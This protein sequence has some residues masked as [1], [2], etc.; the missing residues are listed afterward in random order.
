MK[1]KKR[2]GWKRKSQLHPHHH[3]V[4]W[5]FFIL[6]IIAVIFAGIHNLGS[7]THTSGNQG[8]FFSLG[9]SLTGA[10]V[11]EEIFVE[12]DL[13]PL[14]DIS[15]EAEG[16]E[17]TTNWN[18][19]IPG[20]EWVLFPDLDT[21]SAGNV[22]MTGTSVDSGFSTLV[23]YV[24]K[25]YANGTHDT[26]NWNKTEPSNTGDGFMRVKV[27]SNDE[28]YYL[29]ALNTGTTD[30][31]AIKKYSNDGIL[32]STWNF[33]LTG[34]FEDNQTDAWDMAIDSNDNLFVVG[35]GRYGVD[36]GDNNLF[37][38]KYLA[39]DATEDP[40]WNYSLDLG[41]LDIFSNIVVD[42]NDNVIAAGSVNIGNNIWFLQK[43]NNS[44]DVQW[45]MTFPV[46][47]PDADIPQAL[48]VDSNNDIYIGGYGVNLTA[49]GSE[50]DWRLKKVLA[51]GS[52][53]LT[54]NK[55]FSGGTGN[56]ESV[57]DISIDSNDNIYVTGTMN[58][59]GKMQWMIKKFNT[60]GSED[61]TLW[62]K[63]FDIGTLATSADSIVTDSSGNVFS[64]GV[65]GGAGSELDTGLWGG[66][67]TIK[68]FSGVN[69]APVTS[70]VVLNATNINNNT[71]QNLTTYWD[72]SDADGDNVKNITNW[73]INDTSI[74][75][76][77]MPF[78]EINATAT[79]N[80]W[81]YSGFGNNG[82]VT[83]ATWSATAGYDGFGAYQFD[84]DGDNI[85]L[86]N[87][88]SLNIS[89]AI[90]LEVWINATN[91]G[92]DGTL[93][94]YYKINETEL[95]T[96]VLDDTDYF[97]T[98]VTGIGDLNGDGV[99]DLAVGARG[100][101][102]S[103]TDQGA[104]Y[105]LFMDIS[106]NVDSYYKIN[107]TDL[108]TG[109]LGSNDLFGGSVENIGDLNGDGITDLAVG[110]YND[111]QAVYILFM[112]TNGTLNSYYKISES[113]LGVVLDINDKFG[114]AVTNIGD[115][116]DDGITDL[117]V[118]AYTDDDDID[119][120]P[121]ADQGA[122]Y[123]L[124]MNITGGVDSH[125]KINESDLGAGVLDDN[126]FFGISVAGIGDLNGDGVED[127]A[128]GAYADDDDIDAPPGNNQG[129]VYV[130][131][132]NITGG[133]DSYYKINESDLGAGRLDDSDFFGISLENI[134]DLN[135]D[136]IMDLAVGAVGDDDNIPSPGNGQGA[137]YVLFMNTTG[138]VD[139]YYK[140][141]ESDLG[142]GMLGVNDWFGYSLA[143]V[144]DLNNDG[145]VDLAVGVNGDD[146]D[147]DAPPGNGQGAVYVLFMNGTT[148]EVISKVGSYGINASNSYAV[149]YINNGTNDYSLSG[150]LNSHKWNQVVYTYDGSR[151]KIYINGEVKSDGP[152]TGNIIG[153]TGN[154]ILGDLFNG[155]IDDVKIYNRSLSAEQIFALYNNRTD[156]IVSQELTAGDNWSACITPNDG[157]EDGIE[158]CSGNLTIVAAADTTNPSVGTLV[159]VVNS[160]FNVS[161]VVEINATVTDD[162]A[163]SQVFVNITY[164]NST[165]EQYEL[166]L[167]GSNV[168]NTTFTVPTLTG[169]Y[170]LTF[171]ANDTNN[172]FNTTETSNFT[173][174]LS[175]GIIS[176]ST[177]LT[178]NVTYDGSNNQCFNISASDVT[179]DCNGYWLI[180][181]DNDT[182]TANAAIYSLGTDNVTVK[183][184]NLKGFNPRVI[185][186]I[187][188]TNWTVIDNNFTQASHNTSGNPLYI[189]SN[190][191]GGNNYSNNRFENYYVGSG[192]TSGLAVINFVNDDHNSRAENNY[193]KNFTHVG[194]GVSSFVLTTGQS[195][196]ITHN[197]N[198]IHDVSALSF[199]YP[200]GIIVQGTG[201]IITNNIVN[202]T[203]IAIINLITDTTFTNN[204][205]YNSVL[206]VAYGLA[207]VG[208]ATN[209]SSSNNTFIN[210]TICDSVGQAVSANISGSNY[211]SCTTDAF[212]SGSTDINFFTS[213]V[214]N[215]LYIDNGSNVTFT[216]LTI[217]N[218]STSSV[219]YLNLNVNASGVNTTADLNYANNTLYINSTGSPGLN[220]SSNLTFTGVSYANLNSYN[221][222][223]DEVNCTDCTKSGF[224]P[225]I[226]EVTSFS[227]YSTV[228]YTED[229][230]VSCGTITTNTTLTENLTVNGTC[231]TIGANNIVI[232]GAGYTIT[233]N[234]SSYGFDNDGY[235]NTVIK[236]FAG[237]NN[238]TITVYT[239]GHNQT[240]Y[241]NTMTCANVSSGAHC[242]NTFL[243]S[244]GNNIS[245]NNLTALGSSNSMGIF[246]FQSGANTTI[247]SNSIITYG[248]G[249]S[250]GISLT[251]SNNITLID[252]NITIFG[253][254][255]YGID[256]GG[257]YNN[258]SGGIINTSAGTTAYGIRVT[259]SADGNYFENIQVSSIN[260][261]E[262]YYSTVSS[263]DDFQNIILTGGTNLTIF[264]PSQVTI[265]VNT[266]P[267]ADPSGKQNLSDYL[268]IT[269]LTANGY[270]DFN[271]SYTDS[272]ITG[273][274]E[275]SIRINRYN[276]SSGEW[277]ELA[278]STVDTENNI[279][280][281]GNISSF[282]L[283]APFGS[284]AVTC[285]NVGSSIILTQNLTTDDTC[286]TVTA[287]NV[288]IDG[289]GY[290]IT[291][292]GSIFESKSGV[293]I[294]NR[295]NVTVKNF[296]G[297]NNFSS[298]GIYLFKST[299]GDTN[300]TI[301]N[302]TITSAEDYFGIVVVNSGRNSISN[303]T[304]IAS[305]D[306]SSPLKLE[307][308]HNNTI[309]RNNINVTDA[310]YYAI[311][312]SE[313]SDNFV[314]SNNLIGIGRGI[315]MSDTTDNNT[316]NNIFLN[317][318]LT[319]DA[320]SYAFL[321][322]DSA[323]ANF[324]IYNNS[325]GEI[326]WI[327]QT[328]LDDLD[329]DN[330]I[331][332]GINLFIDN[333]TVALNSSAFSTDIVSAANITLTSLNL[334]SVDDIKVLTTYN[335]S[336]NE[337]LSAGTS[338]IEA[339][340]CVILDYNNTTGRL[341][342]NISSFSSYA[343][344]EDNDTPIISNPTIDPNSTFINISV[345]LNVTVTDDSYIGDVVF[346]IEP[347]GN[348]TANKSGSEYYIVCDATSTCNTT[349]INVYN[350]TSIFANDTVGKS[351][352]T[353]PNL[354]FNITGSQ[355][356]INVSLVSPNSDV[357]FTTNEFTNFS[358]NV[359]CTGVGCGAIQ[360][361]LDP[362]NGCTPSAELNSSCTSS[363]NSLVS[364]FSGTDWYYTPLVGCTPTSP[365]TL[366]AGKD[367]YCDI[368]AGAGTGDCGLRILDGPS[369]Y[370][371]PGYERNGNTSVASGNCSC[372]SGSCGD[373]SALFDLT[374]QFFAGTNTKSGLVSM[375]SNST[376]FWT[377]TSN[378][379]NITLTNGGS[380]LVTWY[381]NA[382]GT[383]NTT[384]EF[385]AY[386]NLTEALAAS[387]QSATINITINDSI[388]SSSSGSSSS[389][390]SSSGG[391]GGGG[392]G[393]GGGFLAKCS[394]N[395]DCGTEVIEEYCRDSMIYKKHTTPTCLDPNLINASCTT[396]HSE[397]LIEECSYGCNGNIC[398]EEKEVIKDNDSELT[399]GLPVTGGVVG[400]IS[401]TSFIDRY[402][403]TFLGVLSLIL[404]IIILFVV[405]SNRDKFRIEHPKI[406]VQSE[407]VKSLQEEQELAAR[408]GL[409]SRR[410]HGFRKR[411][412]ESD[413]KLQRRLAALHQEIEQLEKEG[414]APKHVVKVIPPTTGHKS[415]ST[416]NQRKYKKDLVKIDREL[417][418]GGL[419]RKLWKKPKNII[420]QREEAAALREVKRILRKEGKST[421]PNS[422]LG[423]LDEQLVNIDKQQ[424]KHGRMINKVPGTSS[425]L[426]SVRKRQYQKE[427]KKIEKSL[428]SNELPRKKKQVKSKSKELE[429][430]EKEI[431]KLQMDLY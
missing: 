16:D 91:L 186:L 171:I 160:V 193:I 63:T 223:K 406:M 237:L 45:N 324:L 212:V 169:L 309:F 12:E 360:V 141:N 262:I 112:N 25:I 8:F 55:S 189:F 393:G 312:I 100:D 18:V 6:I 398:A 224:N 34:E 200:G 38:K 41:N 195:Q 254:G 296:A 17:D 416:N 69:S 130:L 375:N 249:G 310:G 347:F 390:S 418:K 127:L 370:Y 321:D 64:V 29:Q 409:L 94:S 276:D 194:T 10:V 344:H 380:E 188:N 355:P 139:S 252:N 301:E 119:A 253:S 218:V 385:F 382:T 419:L 147:V 427:L 404:I 106:G 153:D 305:S 86:G 157:T 376:P 356:E 277:E 259:S 245:N 124:F 294:S 116:N 333:N 71:N 191:N 99:N 57:K 374:D 234:D 257:D 15:I 36:T 74:V 3:S 90:T 381:V 58:I 148:G 136:G 314:D 65:G 84:G 172:N 42:S 383:I 101:D 73:K 274:I 203:N 173:V 146:D 250:A 362:I 227:N 174:D 151:Q 268:T 83:G 412:S 307:D 62:N 420:Q 47:D 394:I 164:P 300:H 371:C 113:D 236:N 363:C 219:N 161:N 110:A 318:N 122:V 341:L 220:V 338:C 72:V 165:L 51:N 158:V 317:N 179:F 403:W 368:L 391:G 1:V 67:A 184:C 421:Q 335:T 60:S 326:K 37:I 204:T 251:L 278:T 168:Y 352:T 92:G 215:S 319:G 328:F 353:D 292:N 232:D 263:S 79:N 82:T 377:N 145:F 402:K 408:L 205:I 107:D 221:I 202:N 97:G 89:G 49:P 303:N 144:G 115:L 213:V 61:G 323:L 167:D 413:P 22:F 239:K 183:N 199:T 295:L 70:N 75:V 32:N 288:T 358:V 359:S 81:D 111:D 39:I 378:P 66:P 282:S 395:T 214:T 155:T 320:V 330:K 364:S 414:F 273:L 121:G 267:P 126:D 117:A 285:G 351:T 187:S 401:R 306:M 431:A 52:E 135:S 78:E 102:G 284:E 365:L 54:W 339:E 387:G 13:G 291:Y 48:A 422:E 286:F 198:E 177:T 424:F 396:I 166:T 114:R 118:G 329:I 175:C 313:S 235:N 196:N 154:L 231:F 255:S 346:N 192:T 197:N 14:D 108:G 217:G 266:T 142:T 182:S 216:N 322:S 190:G 281:S 243:G 109:V 123:I 366:V 415:V 180:G 176:S 156:L 120:P 290:A 348:I 392:S 256:V 138:G 132:M 228:S 150:A 373:T 287:D 23:S 87:G 337:I 240:I 304:I 423:R 134:G 357:N 19:S 429:M 367:S 4:R 88:T 342:F 152:L 44:S 316:N 105:I 289:A 244:E 372:V 21:D 417:E 201:A 98:S 315:L 230:S 343:A 96:G 225:V 143:N 405:Y 283:F 170:N 20:I 206:G 247:A 327:D 229:S 33:N 297:I 5:T 185:D 163:V 80:A 207:G 389:S 399:I 397:V 265:D 238:F 9:N 40:T 129:A 24:T 302:N 27:D 334:T 226:F 279:V 178:E 28:I 211:S 271:L 2:E 242:I 349:D 68:K 336:S 410:L 11:S 43:H 103:E 386:A 181:P 133:V 159:P 30:Y 85:T 241:N 325:F 425:G 209:T 369:I 350:W 53:D 293:L 137:V 275:S 26:T 407:Q 162:T 299:V 77:N 411:I 128:V 260:S 298:R 93:N 261:P 426:S 95:G 149:G 332:L 400:E 31:G 340:T 269:N 264:G 258:I 384:H 430:I 104:V 311:S 272:D 140:I 76:L 270:V 246:A 354:F 428:S 331:G 388:S 56:A 35:S 280:S 208:T 379:F 361:S 248:S 233:G 210:T 308:S 50:R 59:S 46:T 222:T 345:R 125:Y 7:S 131:F